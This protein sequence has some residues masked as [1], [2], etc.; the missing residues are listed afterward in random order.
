MSKVYFAKMNI[1]EQIYEIYEGKQTVKQLINK[2]FA[3]ISTRI[4]IHDEKGGRIKFFNLDIDN[5]GLGVTGNLG[6]IRSGVH[7]SYDPESDTAIDTVDNN[8]IEYITFYFDVEKELLGYTVLPI[9]QR[10]RVLDYFTQL[11]KRGSGVGVEFITESNVDDINSEIKRYSKISKLE[12]K[13]VPPNGDKEDFAE[14][15]SLTAD[16]IQE[17]N[18]TKVTQKF[19]TQR[20]EGIDKKSKLVINYIKSAALGYSE[21]KFSGKDKS[22]NNLEI[23]SSKTVPYTKTVSSYESKNHTKIKNVVEAGINAIMINRTKIREGLKKK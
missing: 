23:D 19:Q 5:E 11:I 9:L 10:K 3:G 2:I 4:D 12:V 22:G 17:S 1:N 15:T 21:I 13:L 8:K 16:R 14:L 6:Y 20:A 7:S 18:T